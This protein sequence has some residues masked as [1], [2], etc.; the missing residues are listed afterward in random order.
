MSSRRALVY[1]VGIAWLLQHVVPF[2]RLVLYPFTLLATWVHETGHGVAAMAT[3]GHFDKLEIFADAS[4]L[5]HTREVGNVAIAIT[6]LGG[7]LAPPIAGAMLLV[8]ARGPR[9]A[10]LALAVL[11]AMM[12]LTVALWVRS[13]AGLIVVALCAGL[14]AWAAWSWRPERRLVLAQFIAVMLALDTVGRMV[15]Y[16][17]SSK[18]TVGGEERTSD[19]AAAADALGANHVLLGALVVTVALALLAVGLWAAWRPSRTG[20]PPRRAPASRR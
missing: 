9:R 15:G 12:V 4:G 11:A 19:V 5:A 8:V 7:M 17:M 3:G 20:P 18:A 14:I 16:A 6:C 2:G 10:R 1:A 13:P